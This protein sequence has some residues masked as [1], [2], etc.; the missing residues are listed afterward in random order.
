MKSDGRGTWYAFAEEAIESTD[1]TK[2]LLMTVS[3]IARALSFA[4][5][6]AIVTLA[7]SLEH[8]P[9]ARVNAAG[10]S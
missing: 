1:K 6:A 9:S 10:Q 4:L 7:A 5:L 2:E 3:H 8:R